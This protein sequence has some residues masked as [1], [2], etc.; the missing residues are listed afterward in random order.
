VTVLDVDR[1]TAHHYATIGLELKRAGKPIP[2]SDRGAPDSGRAALDESC[3]VRIN[4]FGTFAGPASRCRESATPRHS[5][6]KAWLGEIEDARS[7]GMTAA[8]K[9][10]APS[11]STATVM[12]TGL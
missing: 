4:Q 6:R 12:T 2:V 7:A 1:E 8:T 5:A 10:E 11:V 9:A 3:A